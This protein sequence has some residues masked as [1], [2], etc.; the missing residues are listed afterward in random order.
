MYRVVTEDTYRRDVARA[1]ANAANRAGN[2]ALEP[3]VAYCLAVLITKRGHRLDP[4]RD[5]AGQLAERAAAII[6]HLSAWAEL[7]DTIHAEFDAFE[8]TSI[9]SRIPIPERNAEE[10]DSAALRLAEIIAGSPPTARMT[11]QAAYD[12]P[13][14]GSAYVFQSPLD[15]WLVT[16]TRPA[17]DT[18]QIDGH[19]PATDDD[20]VALI[21]RAEAVSEQQLHALV[22]RIAAHFETRELVVDLIARAD[23]FEAEVARMRPPSRLHSELHVKLRAELAAYSDQLFRE[24]RA[25]RDMLAYVV[26]AM[27]QAVKMQAV[28][29]A[30]LRT[31]SID[32]EAV[33]GLA[34]MM[35][36][37]LTDTDQPTPRLIRRTGA[38]VQKGVAQQRLTR[39]E[40][41]VTTPEI[42]GETLAGVAKLLDTLPHV[43]GDD[44]A[45]IA[46]ALTPP[47]TPNIVKTNRGQV[48]E[49]LTHVDRWLVRVFNRYAGGANE[50]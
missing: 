12:D 29:V 27:G 13:P 42:R 10:K 41:L 50:R 44:M 15:R 4:S 16:A 1:A 43:I 8:L 14:A 31:A 5:I 20:L 2:P 38:A 6:E 48:R 21:E 37:L 49:E 18:R 11:L 28:A 46:A 3:Q 17:H 30:S 23:R 24:N 45:S 36:E 33:A 35:R 47:S 22:Q 9:R 32:P 19:E 25:L 40:R 34:T 39:L 7:Y 26:L